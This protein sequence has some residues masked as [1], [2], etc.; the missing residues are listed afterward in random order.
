MK[1]KITKSQFDILIPFFDK[2]AKDFCYEIELE[3][4]DQTLTQKIYENDIRNTFYE[5][6]YEAGYANGFYKG[7]YPKYKCTCGCGGN[8]C[9]NRHCTP[10]CYKYN[11]K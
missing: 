11:N 4:V 3:P 2:S 6:G 10:D 5:R 1:F 7:R 9:W 8:T